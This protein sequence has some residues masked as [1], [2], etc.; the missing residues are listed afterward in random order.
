MNWPDEQVLQAIARDLRDLLGITATPLLVRIRRW[1]GSMPQY[2]VGHLDL[3]QRIEALAGVIL[4]FELAGNYFRGVGIPHCIRTGSLASERLV[5][6]LN[7]QSQ[8]RS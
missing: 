1:T 6:E 3:V 5:A 8:A 2:H 7:R 4:G